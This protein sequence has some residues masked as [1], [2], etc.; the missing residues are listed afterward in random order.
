MV[1]D[2]I[3]RDDLRKKLIERM[4]QSSKVCVS[5]ETSVEETMY[6]RGKHAALRQLLIDYKL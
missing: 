1:S 5:K 6:E 2:L 4:E 3:S